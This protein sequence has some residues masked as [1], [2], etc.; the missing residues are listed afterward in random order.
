MPER[1]HNLPSRYDRLDDQVTGTV[2]DSIIISP[3]SHGRLHLP[4]EH[5]TDSRPPAHHVKISST[6]PD[7]TS[8]YTEQRQL[9]DPGRYLVSYDV[10]N[11]RDS[12]AFA[13]IVLQDQDRQDGQDG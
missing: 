7:N 13:Q 1:K 2:L 3:Q 5:S 10:W 6:S 12:P 8:I 4:G 9:G 11:Y